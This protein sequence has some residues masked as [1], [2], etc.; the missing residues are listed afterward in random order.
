MKQILGV[1]IS[2]LHSGS[3]VAPIPPGFVTEKGLPVGQTSISKEV[4]DAYISLAT[5]PKWHRPDVLI[6]LGESIDGKNRK[7]AGVGV[8]SPSIRDQIKCASEFLKMYDSKLYYVLDASAYHED[9]EG[10]PASEWVARDLNA[11]PMGPGTMRISER[12]IIEEFGFRMHL[13]HHVPVSQ[14][15]W[16]F[17][18]PMAKEGIRL[19]LSEHDI[20][21]IDAILRGH[22]HRWFGAEFRS[23][24]L[25]QCPAWKLP[26]KYLFRSTGEPRT[27]IGALRFGIFSEPD[28]WNAV[29]RYEKKLFKIVS[30]R[31][32]VSGINDAL[33]SA[34]FHPDIITE[35]GAV[36]GEEGRND[37][38]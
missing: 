12:M 33:S 25:L 2:D 22:V 10:I 15:D 21:K 35:V 14:S 5:K 29:F 7:S 26:D 20:G 34:Y 31:P 24:H 16:Y 30:A 19:Q 3:E 37:K 8:W 32:K 4:T 13:A 23:Q 17:T 11:F 36:Y 38:R 28:E 27:D 6:D 18:T 1:V 9:V